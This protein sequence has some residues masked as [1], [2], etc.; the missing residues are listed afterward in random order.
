MIDLQQCKIVPLIAPTQAGVTAGT[1][2][3]GTVDAKGWDYCTVV[4]QVQQTT[5]TNQTNAVNVSDSDDNTTFVTVAAAQSV[6]AGAGAGIIRWDIDL[7]GKKRYVKLTNIQ[8]T[9]LNGTGAVSGLAILSRGKEQPGSTS[10]LVGDAVG[11]TNQPET[12]VIV[13]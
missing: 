9:V 12:S 2:S 8:G 11:A 4:A 6:T 13:D 10:D 5:T 3:A 1:T 7:R